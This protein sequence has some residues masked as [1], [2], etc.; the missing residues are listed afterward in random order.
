MSMLKVF[1][2]NTYND[3]E[4]YN[5]TITITMTAP[6]LDTY[7][8]SPNNDPELTKI[9]LFSRSAFYIRGVRLY[10][11]VSQDAFLTMQENACAF[12]MRTIESNNAVNSNP[13][14]IGDY[15]Y[16]PLDIMYDNSENE[17]DEFIKISI[18]GNTF[19]SSTLS[20]EQ[21]VGDFKIFLAFDIIRSSNLEFITDWVQKGFESKNP[22][23]SKRL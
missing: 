6:Q 16:I 9:P 22:L 3:L 1:P 7:Y 2:D 12:N 19:K 5:P 20:I 10:A 18:L 4:K 8:T 14:G 15:S 11:N 17:V 23:A 21:G 13:V